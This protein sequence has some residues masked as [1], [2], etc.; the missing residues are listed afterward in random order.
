M[1]TFNTSHSYTEM[2]EKLS[3]TPETCSKYC[4]N[5]G[6][7]Y[8]V[9]QTEKYIT[10]EN[11]SKIKDLYE[12]QN[13]SCRKIE[14]EIHIPRAVVQKIINDNKFHKNSISNLIQITFDELND[15]YVKQKLST[16]SIANKYEVSYSH[17]NNLLQKYNIPI[18]QGYNNSSQ[19]LELENHLKENNIYFIS[20]ERSL[21]DGKEIDIYIPSKHIGIEFNG[22]YWHN[23]F[24]KPIDYHQKK[25]LLAQ[26]KGI[27]L[28]QIFEYEWKTNKDKLLKIIDN[29]LKINQIILNAN[30]CSIKEVQ[31]SIKKQFLNDNHI[32]GNIK[33]SFNLGLYHNNE[34]VYIMSFLKVSNSTH[35]KLIR[36]C[37]KLGY[38]IPNGFQILLN[39]FIKKF[40]PPEIQFNTD[41]LKDNP[42]DLIQ[43][44]FKPISILKPTYILSNGKSTIIPKKSQRNLKKNSTNFYKIYNAGFQKWTWKNPISLN[45]PK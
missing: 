35:L 8:K 18:N 26:D 17:I 33:S 15:L 2:A 1:I 16:I 14:K 30:I 28:F 20:N 36:F 34:L 21:L 41:L 27:F 9:S 25:A 40:N 32:Q 23:E 39:H 4:K 31:P 42:I 44:G 37:S 43:F 22:D 45:F 5:Y 19:E 24:H 12:N 10:D 29:F 7:K 6:L 3:T 13:L 38:S 11:I